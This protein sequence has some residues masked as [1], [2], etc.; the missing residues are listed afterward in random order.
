MMEMEQSHH[1]QGDERNIITYYKP[2]RYVPTSPKKGCLERF[3][4]VKKNQDTPTLNVL[5]MFIFFF[6]LL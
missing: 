5:S 3:I 4:S 1:Y 2:C 6:S